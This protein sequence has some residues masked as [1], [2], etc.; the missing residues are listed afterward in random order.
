MNE[1]PERFTGGKT[2]VAA[3]TH[4]SKETDVVIQGKKAVVG[5][6]ASLSLK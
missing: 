6:N 5:V 4:G 1:Q 3:S 2:L